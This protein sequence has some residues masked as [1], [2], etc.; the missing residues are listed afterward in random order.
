MKSVGLVA[1]SNGL[2][3]EFTPYYS[4][5]LHYLNSLE[6]R[7]VQ[8]SCIFSKNGVF[9]GSRAERAEE[10]MK[11]F[12]DP[13]IEE[14]YDVSGGDL[15]NQIL[16]YL[17][18]NTIR[19]SNAVFWGYSDLTTILNAIYTQTGKSGV[20][21]QVRHLV[22]G[23]FQQVQQHRFE[24]RKE[25][26]Q[27]SF[28]FIQGTSMSGIVVGGNI[29]CF[30][31]LAGTPY[32]PDLQGKLLLLESLGGEIS[33]MATYLAQ[34]QQLGAFEKIQGILLGTFTAMEQ[35]GC[36]PDIISLVKE[37]AGPDMPIAKT[38]EIGHGTDAKAMIIGENMV[39]SL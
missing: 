39:L 6:Y 20:L 13:A 16:P 8:S 14:I 36:S 25:L 23:D 15:A 1:C 19:H 33:Q 29:R 24:N 28:T 3:P 34:L 7:I 22:A 12:S 38:Q 17:D 27:P 11:M 21:Y 32:F 31:K 2:F 4:K 35:N 30:L 18:W 9:S 26:F 5:L 37:V 10:L